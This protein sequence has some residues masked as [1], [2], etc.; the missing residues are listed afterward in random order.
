MTGSKRPPAA[1]SEEKRLFSQ[2][3]TGPELENCWFTAD[4][5]A[6][7]LVDKNKAA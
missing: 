1:M 6:A 2:I 3:T 7:M 4:I 5:T